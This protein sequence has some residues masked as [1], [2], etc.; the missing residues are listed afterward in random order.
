VAKEKLAEVYANAED[1]VRR[2][3][4]YFVFDRVDV[5]EDIKFIEPL[6]YRF[7]TDKIYYPLKT[8]NLIGGR[9]AVE[10]ILVLPGSISDDIWQRVR[11][12]SA[13]GLLP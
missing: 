2:G 11:A 10:L 9:G 5:S 6:M 1:Y 8:S 13:R 12:G 3:I 7:R 4:T